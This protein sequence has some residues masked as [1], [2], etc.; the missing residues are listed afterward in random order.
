MGTW[1]WNV[2]KTTL[3]VSPPAVPDRVSHWNS[4][5]II[6][7]LTRS[8]EYIFKKTDICR[9]NFKKFTAPNARMRDQPASPVPRVR[10]RDRPFSESGS[11]SSAF[12]A[13]SLTLA[14]KRKRNGTC[15]IGR[16][17]LARARLPPARAL[18]LPVLAAGRWWPARP[19]TPRK[20]GPTDMPVL[21]WLLSRA[22]LSVHR[23]WHSAQW[24]LRAETFNKHSINAISLS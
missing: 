24:P 21:W 9:N 8:N 18:F 10:R 14:G 13:E 23:P 7:R 16:W 2:L 11:G 20:S 1:T 22:Q 3:Y 6:E 4:L 17:C 15:S 12:H 19:P 5:A